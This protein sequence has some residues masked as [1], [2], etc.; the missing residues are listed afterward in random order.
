MR[1]TMFLTILVVFLSTAPADAQQRPTCQQ[2]DPALILAIITVHE[3]GWDS[4]NDMRGIHA[5]IQ[6]V[7]ARAGSS[8]ATAA[9]IHSPRALRGET[10]RPWVSTLDPRGTEPGSWPRVTTVCRRG[11]CAVTAHAPWAAY[12][13][14]WLD[15]LALA[16]RVVSEPSSGATCPSCAT[17]TPATWGSDDDV[18]RRS[19]A[20]RHW[21]DVD[22]GETRN[23]FGYWE[24][25]RESE[26]FEIA[27]QNV[28]VE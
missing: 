26:F 12:R 15:V 18:E 5:V 14:R 11:A 6:S 22:C 21:V 3:A 7:A 13:Q 27:G 25:G 17:C 4:E 1:M 19:S 28:D 2:R 20:T 24:N 23:R 10:T 8:Y 16:R 9:C